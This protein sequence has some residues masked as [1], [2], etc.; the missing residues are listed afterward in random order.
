MA[1]PIRAALEGLIA[2]WD[3][4]PITA[5]QWDDGW[6]DGLVKALGAARAALAAQ[7]PAPV[8]W[9]RSDDFRAA[10]AKC[11]SFSGWREHHHDCDMALYAAQPTPEPTSPTLAEAR[12]AARQLAGPAAEVVHRFLDAL[13]R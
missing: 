10:A 9:C 2:A 4:D 12:E 13:P 11:Q 1:D 6:D 5:H 3:R 8:A 7:P